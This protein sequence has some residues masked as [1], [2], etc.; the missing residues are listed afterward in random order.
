MTLTLDSTTAIELFRPSR[1][2][3]KMYVPFPY[4]V[5]WSPSGPE[6]LSRVEPFPKC[7]ENPREFLRGRH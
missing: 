2:L 7:H 3:M 1:P 4:F 6:S 5:V